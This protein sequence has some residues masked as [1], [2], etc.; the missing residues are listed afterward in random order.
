MNPLKTFVA[1]SVIAGLFGAGA[2]VAAEDEHKG[3]HPEGAP[4]KAEAAP[5]PKGGM[6]GMGMGMMG[7]DHMKQM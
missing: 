5:P 2:L 4:P 6:G 7:P 1:V 3:H